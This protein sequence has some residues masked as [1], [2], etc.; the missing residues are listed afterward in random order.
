M[1][2]CH[3][4]YTV[5]EAKLEQRDVYHDHDDC[6]D[7]KRI[8]TRARRRVEARQAAIGPVTG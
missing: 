7:G 1:A 2:K 3:P 5:T 6:P 4:Y 8:M